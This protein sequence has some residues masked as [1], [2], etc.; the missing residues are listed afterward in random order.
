MLFEFDYLKRKD[1]RAHWIH[2]TASNMKKVILILT[3]SLASSLFGNE[4]Y[5]PPPPAPPGLQEAE[6][7]IRA[8][9]AAPKLTA[10]TNGNLG[11][12]SGVAAAIGPPSATAF[13]VAS[14]NSV[15]ATGQAR[16]TNQAAL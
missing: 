5:P 10:Q 15:V 13:R 1:F 12:Q 3:L 9:S 6:A 16:T 11:Q 8:L 7:K 2:S 4:K 14:T